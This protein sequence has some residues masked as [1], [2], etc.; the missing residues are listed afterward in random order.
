MLVT[1]LEALAGVAQH[2]R[3]RG[4]HRPALGRPV[5]KAAGQ[6]DCDRHLR[7]PLFERSVARAGRTHDIGN[8]PSLTARKHTRGG[9]AGRSIT[10]PLSQCLLQS[11][12]N[13]CQE[14]TSSAV[15]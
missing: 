7:V 15:L 5:L 14:P 8:R 12:S 13:F 3:S 2:G 9:A 1:A 11:D 4:Q 10:S 6:D